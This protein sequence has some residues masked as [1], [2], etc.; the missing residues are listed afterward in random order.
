MELPS[1]A[2]RR[3]RGETHHAC[4]T[5]T[6]GGGNHKLSRVWRLATGTHKKPNCFRTHTHLS[7]P[8]RASSTSGTCACARPVRPPP[9]ADCM[10]PDT[11]PA[12]YGFSTPASGLPQLWISRNTRCE[13]SKL[14]KCSTRN[15]VF[16]GKTHGT[17]TPR[18]CH[19]IPFNRKYIY[20]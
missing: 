17:R 2:P 19:L 12:R 3:I 14:T 6:A 7:P 15:G 5:H 20:I 9:G 8:F 13:A 11:K 10:N 1:R 18:H 4:R 16:R